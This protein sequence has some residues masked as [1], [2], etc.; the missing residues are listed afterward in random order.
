MR[1]WQFRQLGAHGIRLDQD[2]MAFEPL[3]CHGGVL[4]RLVDAPL[5]AENRRLISHARGISY[6]RLD[7][8]SSTALRGRTATLTSHARRSRAMVRCRI[9]CRR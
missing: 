9:C 5:T 4:A 8:S 3:E 7:N 6:T 2:A 1:R